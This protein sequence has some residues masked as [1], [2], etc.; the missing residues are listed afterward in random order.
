MQVHLVFRLE[1]PSVAA[2]LCSSKELKY[3][4]FEQCPARRANNDKLGLVH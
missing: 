2:C 3:G 4:K 1:N